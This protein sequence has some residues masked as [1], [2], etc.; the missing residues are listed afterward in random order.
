MDFCFFSHFLVLDQDV[1]FL[2]FLF[3]SILF[4]FVLRK[5]DLP[6]IFYFDPSAPLFVH[7]ILILFFDF[8]LFF[9]TLKRR[10]RKK[11]KTKKQKTRKQEQESPQNVVLFL[12]IIENVS[13]KKFFFL[14]YKGKIK[15]K[16]KL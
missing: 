6:L 3:Q 11:Q 10:R 7:L 13:R 1:D 4:F 5:L 16:K 2:N 8:L 15:N 12:E 9:P 14:F